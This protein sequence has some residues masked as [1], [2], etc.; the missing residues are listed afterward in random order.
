MNVQTLKAELQGVLHGTTNNQITNIDGVLNRA[1][2]QVLLDVDPQETKRIVPISTPLYDGVFDY[3]CPSDLKGNKVID[4]K[5]Q[6]GRTPNQMFDQ[7]YNQHFDITKL[8]NFQPSFTMNFDTAIKSL[9]INAPFLNTGIVL[10]NANSPTSNGNW[11]VGGTASS[12]T[13]NVINYVSPP[14]SVS[15]TLNAGANP[16]TGYIENSTFPAIDL[17]TQ[18]GQS[19]IFYYVYLPVAANVTSVT[20][21]WGTNSTNYWTGT[22]TT[23]NESTVFQNGWNLIGFDWVSASKVGNPN[24]AS[25]G[26]LKVSVT[27]NGT[28]MVGVLVNNIVS[29]VGVIYD[30][31]YYSKCIFR[32]ASTG[33]FQETVTDD[34]NLINLDTE[35]YNLLFYQ[36]AWMAV[37]QM[38]GQDAV[39]DNNYFGQKYEDALARYKAMYKSEITLPKSTYYVK[40]NTSF[41]RFVGSRYIS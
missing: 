41:D 15:F 35:S 9:R 39:Y 12:I 40:Q 22:S 8:W 5:P 26:Y 16:S 3:P 32:D 23:T 25:I 6:V 38:L 37:Q 29:R 1:A 11:V 10:N 19:R 36:F 27:Y 7:N 31:E 20:I 30:L 28:Q 4:I 13:T 34:S 17:S 24:S 14:S 18:N 21:A 33:A 2:R